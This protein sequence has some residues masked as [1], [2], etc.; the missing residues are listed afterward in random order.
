[1]VTKK[2]STSETEGTKGRVKV[3]RLNLNKETVKDLAEAEAKKVQGGKAT[4]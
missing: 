3:G 2:K 1:M 4:S